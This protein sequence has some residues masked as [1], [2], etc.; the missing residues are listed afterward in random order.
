LS[1]QRTRQQLTVLILALTTTAMGQSLFF[2]ILAPAVSGALATFSLLAPL[3]S[4]VVFFVVL[5]IEVFNDQ[6]V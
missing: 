1:G 6:S 5:L 3:F 2:A 4:A